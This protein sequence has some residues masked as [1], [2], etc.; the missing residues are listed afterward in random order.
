MEAVPKERKIDFNHGFHLVCRQCSFS[1]WLT[2][3]E[4]A[5][6]LGK[7]SDCQQCRRQYDV[8]PEF[9]NHRDPHDE[10]I[11]STQLHDF[12][13]YH[14]TLET[15]WPSADYKW[16]AAERANYAAT[17][18]PEELNNKQSFMEDQAFHLGT[19]EAAVENMLRLW[20][21][22][23]K[24][25]SQFY[26][27][28]VKLRD[29]LA[30]PAE[31][32]SDR[33]TEKITQASIR[34]LDASGIKYLNTK[35]SVG[36]IS[37]AVVREAIA[38]TQ[39]ISVPPEGLV[40]KLSPELMEKLLDMRKEADRLAR[41]ARAQ[42]SLTA[43]IKRKLRQMKKQQPAAADT[44]TYAPAMSATDSSSDEGMTDLIAHEYLKGV[45]PLL[46]QQVFRSTRGPA[47]LGQERDDQA[48]LTL[49][50]NIAPFITRPN[51][52]LAALDNQPWEDVLPANPTCQG[53]VRDQE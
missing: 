53:S 50:L 12:Y 10:V 31:V 25:D 21:E 35:E 47:P 13:W 44:A 9:A 1:N 45:P 6:A 30:F 40:E 14:S 16:A 2:A 51:A 3:E 23:G 41:I 28:R 19:Y 5:V 43:N 15:N 8:A 11:A 17:M 29:G 52:V 24:R 37:L 49:T 33:D 39:R 42:E 20:D 48:W 7:T 46:R 34:G 4:Y 38:R 18:S 26:L 22:N 27:H 36:S 32:H